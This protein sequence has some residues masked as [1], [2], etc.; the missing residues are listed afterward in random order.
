MR[1]SL[2]SLLALPCFDPQ[3]YALVDQFARF[4]GGGE[5][6]DYFRSKVWFYP[7]LSQDEPWAGQGSGEG[8]PQPLAQAVAAPPPG[9]L[10]TKELAIHEI[11]SK[12]S[13]HVA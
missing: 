10:N 3:W 13:A 7:P 8:G 4:K 2:T 1:K 6:G 12:Q 9:L 5:A 11:Q